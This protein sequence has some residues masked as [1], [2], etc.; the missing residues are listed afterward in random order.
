M[1]DLVIRSGTII[2]GRKKARFQADIGLIGDKIAAVG[3]IDEGQS[4]LDASGK[5]V[6]PG[7][8]DVHTHTD[9]WL[10]K[11]EN[12]FSKTGQGFTTEVIMADGISYAPL[13]RHTAHEWLYY[14]RGLNGLQLTDY[15]GWESIA[16][17]MALLDRR[18]AQN[19]IPHIPYANVRTLACGFGR[20]GPDDVQMSHIVSE[21]EKG[22]AAGAVGL[23]TGLDYIVEC[24]ATT[25]ELV[26]ACRPLA[27][28][29]GLYVTHIRYRKGMVRALQEAVDIGKRAGVP[30]HIS[31]LKG[32][33]STPTLNE[34]VLNFINEVAVNEVDFS[35]DVYPYM[36]SSTMLNYLFPPE[37]WQDGP[38][39]V[40]KHLRRP[41]I[42]ARTAAALAHID[43]SHTYIAWLP[44]KANSRFQ[45]RSL[46]HYLDTIGAPPVD[47]LTN[48]LI[49][50][51]LAVLLVFRI[52]DDRLIEPFLQHPC[53]MM[54]TD[55]IFQDG[56]D[57]HPRHFGSAARLLGNMVRDRGLFSLE[58]AVY[59]MTGYPA[60][61]FGL[62]KRGEI[63]EGNFADLV[64]FD[65]DAI[66]DRATMSAPQQMSVGVEQV[67]VNGAFI[68]RDGHPVTDFEDH[69]PGRALSFRQ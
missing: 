54:G 4:V 29:Q 22:V 63:V 11:H 62:T 59:K 43:L 31:H 42:Q 37:I 24:W 40:Y 33:S 13:N 69:P 58:E 25:D 66:A 53:Y 38:L 23:S 67:L 50:E 7:F 5:I 17:Y 3:R 16:D 41:E 30:V 8:I 64:I 28:Q 10:L 39:Q 18:T 20:S 6:A 48:L 46:Q 21:V 56:G 14:L 1:Y 51:N 55:G 27:A 52:G 26:E 35:F 9:G 65:K 32:G 19:T 60:A 15:T 45:G 2:D 12:L 36:A 68:V 47:G 61:R 34:D 49:E 44:G 57:V